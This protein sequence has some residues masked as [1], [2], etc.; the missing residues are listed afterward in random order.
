MAVITVVGK[1]W[2]D[3]INGNTYHSVEVYVDGDLVGYI[4]LEYGYDSAY[5]QTALNLLKEKHANIKGLYC[6]SV[7]WHL[8]DKGH[9]IINIV[10]DVA[11]KKDL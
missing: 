2:F 6:C 4:P 7:L 8:R 3:R 11:R 10:S 9:K 1:R 5:E